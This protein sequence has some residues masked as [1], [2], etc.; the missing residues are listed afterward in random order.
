LVFNPVNGIPIAPTAEGF[1]GALGTWTL[2]VADSDFSS[3][4]TDMIEEVW[5]VLKYKIALS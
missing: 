2:A 4:D 5:M 1:S 3:L